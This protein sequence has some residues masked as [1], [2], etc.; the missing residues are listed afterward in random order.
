MPSEGEDTAMAPFKF[1]LNTLILFSCVVSVWAA[2]TPEPPQQLIRDVV[3]NELQDHTS[4]GYWEFLLQKRVG[5]KVTTEERIETKEGPVYRLLAIDGG[6]LSPS[7]LQEEEVRLNQ[8]IK[9]PGQQRKLK[10]QYDEDEARISRIVKLLPEAFLF[11]YAPCEDNNF[12]LNFRPN[13]SFRPQSIEARV[14]HAMQGSIWVSSS[15]K[16]FVRLQGS[17]IEDLSF[18]FGLLGHL[19]KG[20]WFDVQRVQV[21]P[22]DW[23]TNH[24][25]VHITGKAIF[26]KTVAKDTEEIRS[27]FHEVAPETSV[28]QAK[29]IL[30]QKQANRT[31]WKLPVPA[32]QASSFAAHP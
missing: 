9:D 3:Y 23:K 4:H 12:R 14:F 19:D 30:D 2:E 29:A 1:V 6:T 17:L 15:T 25:V 22:N 18:G 31:Q 21:S 16:H 10:Q 13:P 24:L 5:Q 7:Q 28:G 26:F 8:L 27:N 32:I 11:E 20:G